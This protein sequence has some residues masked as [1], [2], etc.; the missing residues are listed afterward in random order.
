MMHYREGAPIVDLL[1]KID[2]YQQH[3]FVNHKQVMD[4]NEDLLDVASFLLS[5]SH[6]IHKQSYVIQLH[7]LILSHG[8]LRGAFSTPGTFQIFDRPAFVLQTG[9]V[10]K[11]GQH[12]LKFPGFPENLKDSSITTLEREKM[13]ADSQSIFSKHPWLTDELEVSYNSFLMSDFDHLNDSIVTTVVVYKNLSIFLPP[14]FL[15]RKGDHDIETQLCSSMMAVVLK[16]R[17]QMI[18]FEPNDLKVQLTLKRK[19]SIKIGV[20]NVSCAVVSFAEGKFKFHLDG[21]QQTLKGSYIVCVCNQTGFFAALATI[22]NS[23]PHTHERFDVIVGIGC[24]LCICLVLVTVLILLVFWRR[25]KGPLT[26]LKIQSCMAVLGTYSCF[27]GALYESFHKE[28]YP[29]VVSLVMFFLL[30]AICMH[31]CMELTICMEFV[32]LKT[33]QHLE[34]K[35]AAMG[36]AVPVIV[37]GATL[38]AQVLEGFDLDSWWLLI[39]T[40]FFYAFVT[41]GTI[42]VV[43]EKYMIRLYA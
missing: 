41:S 27:L 33:I 43:L 13:K 25:I 38:A 29:H 10:T 36:W 1:K 24:A 22:V 28:Y 11:D 30:A 19:I 39:G 32:Q 20:Q 40:S 7:Q 15:I 23:A 42:I 31:L 3:Y 5:N 4:T 9:R 18:G 12:N 26:A 35:I 8:F 14:R 6:V 16:S 34:K 2:S 17:H 21:C 37:V